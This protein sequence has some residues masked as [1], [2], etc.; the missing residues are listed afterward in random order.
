MEDRELTMEEIIDMINQ[1]EGEVIVHV[2]FGK[3][4]SNGERKE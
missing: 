2:D 4:D 1:S 3:G